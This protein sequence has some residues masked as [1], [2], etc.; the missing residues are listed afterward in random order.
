VT[1]GGE[2]GSKEM[3]IIHLTDPSKVCSLSFSAEYPNYRVAG[4]SGGLLSSNN[5]MMCG[6]VAYDGNPPTKLSE[7]FIITDSAIVASARLEQPRF[8]AASVVLNCNTLWIT[9]GKNDVSPSSS[10]T[11]STELV[12]LTGIMTGPD[13][14]L[15]VSY[16]CLLSLNATTVLLI[17]GYLGDKSNVK[18]YTTFYYNTDDKTWSNGP[19]LI[20]ARSDHSCALFKSPQYGHTDTV[21][22]TGGGGG[23]DTILKSTEFLVLDS[24][25]WTSGR[26]I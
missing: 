25:S 6:G 8:F 19:P 10:A 20:T 22:V 14:P 24:N 17:G 23:G 9:G 15:A 4:A 7:C 16:H 2:V 3:Q 5:T 1:T 11:Q 18:F 21:I 12:M 13:L 26:N